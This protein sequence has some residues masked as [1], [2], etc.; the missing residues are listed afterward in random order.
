MYS[1]L[2]CKTSVKRRPPKTQPP[3]LP[4]TFSQ[5][6]LTFLTLTCTFKHSEIRTPPYVGQLIVVPV[7][8]L[9]QRFHCTGLFTVVPVVSL[10]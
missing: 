5:P 2:Y 4:D 7:I 10:L 8:S 6:H 9:L 1:V 3:H